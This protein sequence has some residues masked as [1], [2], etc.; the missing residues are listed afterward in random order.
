MSIPDIAIEDL[1]AL[2]ATGVWP[3]SV[4]QFDQQSIMAVKTAM[5]AR[6]PLLIRG[7]PGTG[8][9]QLAR[10]VARVW[11]RLFVS[12][13]VNAQTES[14]DLMWHFDA[15]ARLGEAQI[16]QQQKSLEAAHFLSPGALW[17]AF[18]YTS[19]AS[20]YEQ[21]RYR[22]LEPEHLPNWK[23]EQGC[24]VLIDEIDKADAELP[25]GLLEILGNGAFS[26][27]N[28]NQ[29]VGLNATAPLVV[30][31]TNEERELPAAFVRRCMVLRLTLPEDQQ[32][33]IDWLVKR[34]RCHFSKQNLSDSVLKESAQQL[35]QDRDKARQL[36]LNQPGQA[37]YIDLL[38]ALVE[39]AEGQQAQLQLLKQISSY[40]FEKYTSLE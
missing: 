22:Q 39:L 27:P 26:V 34:G 17:W 33:L 4:H 18:D 37:E 28:I 29:R 24:V 12:V 31:T 40:A 2:P 1:I 38:R 6:R 23:V 9:S 11:Q 7:E 32:A 10:A 15:I 35:A 14:Q 16:G 19:A 36:G 25:N 13:V 21:C 8:K 5:A 30:I 20:Q 3:E